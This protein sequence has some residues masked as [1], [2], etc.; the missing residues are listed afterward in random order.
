VAAAAFSDLDRTPLTRSGALAIGGSFD[1]RGL[2]GRRQLAK[3]AAWQ[4][5]ALDR[6]SGRRAA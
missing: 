5:L 3:A 1:D 6:S 2:I 4:F